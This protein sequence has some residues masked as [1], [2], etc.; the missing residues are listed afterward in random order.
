LVVCP[1]NKFVRLNAF[2][3]LARPA[4]WVP[5]VTIALA[6]RR[7]VAYNLYWDTGDSS[8]HPDEHLS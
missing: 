4:F 8:F 5:S 6:R 1:N 7:R 2:K 3:A